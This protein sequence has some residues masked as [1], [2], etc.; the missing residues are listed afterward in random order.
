MTD[1]QNPNP[2]VNEFVYNDP[3]FLGPDD[4]DHTEAFADTWRLEED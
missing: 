4:Q 1:R 3:P 2:N